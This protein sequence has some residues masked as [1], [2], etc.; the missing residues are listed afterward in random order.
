MRRDLNL[1]GAF[2]EALNLHENGKGRR[3]KAVLEAVVQTAM[4]SL[5]D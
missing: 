4:L 2:M 5:R 3:I 1:A